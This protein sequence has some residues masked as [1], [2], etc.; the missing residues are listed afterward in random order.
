MRMREAPA[1]VRRTSR[2]GGLLER[3]HGL[4]GQRVRPPAPRVGPQLELPGA[5]C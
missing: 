3:Q 4:S 2:C 5:G 1:T